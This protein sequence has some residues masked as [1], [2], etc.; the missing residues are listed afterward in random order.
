VRAYAVRLRDAGASKSVTAFEAAAEQM[1]LAFDD[2]SLSNTS[3]MP[4][5]LLVSLDVGEVL[6]AVYGY[7]ATRAWMILDPM[8]QP[9]AVLDR[10]QRMLR[11]VLVG[12]VV[13]ASD[14]RRHQEMPRI[15]LPVASL[16]KITGNSALR[17]LYVRVGGDGKIAYVP[18]YE[19][20]AYVDVYELREYTP[21]RVH[22][23]AKGRA[24]TEKTEE[25]QTGRKYLFSVGRTNSLFA[26]NHSALLDG[27]VRA[28]EGG[29]MVFPLK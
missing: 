28:A 2:V 7:V 19:N 17:D 3:Q 21:S 23:A 1:P 4:P 6:T 9:E 16:D 11:E 5:E 25:L 13:V 24:K 20:G 12:T 8:N 10:I 26:A 18:G 14:P 29:P 15:P 27:C 22:A